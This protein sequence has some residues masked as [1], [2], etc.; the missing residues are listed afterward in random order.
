M[1]RGAPQARTKGGNDKESGIS[2]AVG[3]ETQSSCW[4]ETGQ[5]ILDNMGGKRIFGSNCL[6]SSDMGD[7]P[8]IQIWPQTSQGEISEQEVWEEVFS[9]I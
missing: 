7:F 1:G 2:V 3:R 9:L 6:H 5:P 8:R 4:P